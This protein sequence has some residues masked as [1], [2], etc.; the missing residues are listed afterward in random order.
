MKNAKNSLIKI[1]SI[2]IIILFLSTSMTAFQAKIIPE[3]ND[4]NK[5]K[6]EKTPLNNSY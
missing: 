5:I 4:L 1:F 2:V 6:N 3:K